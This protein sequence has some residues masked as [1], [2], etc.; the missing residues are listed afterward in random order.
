MKILQ[1]Q[2]NWIC[3]G[4]SWE[5]PATRPP[6]LARQVG[7]GTSLDCLT[8]LSSVPKPVMTTAVRLATGHDYLQAP[9]QKTRTDK[10]QCPLCNNSRMV[11]RQLSR[12]SECT[13]LRK[14]SAASLYW[15]PKSLMIQSD[16]KKMGT[17]EK[18]NKNW[19]NP[20][21][22]IYWQKL[23]HYNLPFKRQ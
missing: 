12:T 19:R 23:N 16:T 1:D 20:R 9:F 15:T 14:K 8:M 22:K 3:T 18:P 10:D 4:K 17:F 11:T 7:T 2:Y 21:K 6:I 5:H 13:K